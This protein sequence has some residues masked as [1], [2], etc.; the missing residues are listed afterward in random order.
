VSD[1]VDG[2]ALVRAYLED[3]FTNGNVAKMDRYLAGD[4]FM[5]SVADLVATWRSAFSDFRIVVDD[6]LADGDKVV[7]VE[8]LSGTHDGVYESTI[9]RV[10]PTGKAV[11]WSRI[12]I[13]TL[14]DGRFVKGFFEEDEVGLLQQMGAIELANDWAAAHRS[15]A[16]ANRA[17]AFRVLDAVATGEEERRQ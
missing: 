13:R 16:P 10:E 2:K 9:G 3:V 11:R 8:I 4:A 1:E 15:A 17:D 6:A 14:K 7:S 12:A 5:A